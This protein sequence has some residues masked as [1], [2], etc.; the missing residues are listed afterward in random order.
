MRDLN[1]W[2]MNVEESQ[3]EVDAALETMTDFKSEVD[4]QK[5]VV[6]ELDNIKLLQETKKESLSE[7]CATL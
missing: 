7:V 1:A 6:V 3:I 5:S 4:R 2:L